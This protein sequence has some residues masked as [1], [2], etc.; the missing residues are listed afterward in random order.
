MSKADIVETPV[1]ATAKKNGKAAGKGKA[2][3]ANKTVTRTR[4]PLPP[5]AL[6]SSLSVARLG[7]LK[8][9][10]SIDGGKDV[11]RAKLDAKCDKFGVTAHQVKHHL[12]CTR[13][14]HMEPAMT[15]KYRDS[16]GVEYFGFT[17]IGR[18]TLDGIVKKAAK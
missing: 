15:T 11:L 9:L 4:S 13:S 2:T 18:K 17:P 6:P 7:V 12:Y 10:A 1:V 3:K 8:L 16:E 14:P 5:A